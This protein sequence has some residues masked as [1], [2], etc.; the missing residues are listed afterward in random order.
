MKRVWLCVKRHVLPGCLPCQGNQGN[1]REINPLSKLSGNCQGNLALLPCLGSV[2]ETCPFSLTSKNGATSMIH[3]IFVLLAKRAFSNI[4]E[5][6][7]SENF[8]LAPLAWSSP[9][10]FCINK[11]INL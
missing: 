11:A 4:T 8:L 2:R 9:P 1:V 10:T 3:I 6:V 7:D 5:G